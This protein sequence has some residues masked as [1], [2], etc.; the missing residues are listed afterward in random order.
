MAAT[1]PLEALADELGAVAARIERELRLTV[2]VMLA[3][4]R[5]E[6]SGLRASR[7]ESELRA[8]RAIAERLTTLQD[9]PPGPQGEAGERGSPGEAIIGPPGEPGPPGPPGATGEAGPPGEVPYLGEVCGLYDRTR[10][11][12]KFDLVSWHGSEWR[13]K[14]DDPGPLPGDGWALSGQAGGRG[15]A[16]EKGERGPPGPAAPTI[17]DWAVKEYRAAPIMSDGSTGA[18]LDLQGFF[19]LYHGQR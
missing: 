6:M 4:I 7:A 9:G 14:H 17:V 19:E 11:Y 2:S 15:K 5:E 13:A 16:G 10:T 3:E 18:V 8:E 1:S 12:L